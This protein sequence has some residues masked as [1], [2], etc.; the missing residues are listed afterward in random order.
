MRC[1][2]FPNRGNP[3][4]INFKNFSYY[5]TFLLKKSHLSRALLF[6]ILASDSNNFV[7]QF[8]KEENDIGKDLLSHLAKE[9]ESWVQTQASSLLVHPPQ[10]NKSFKSMVPNFVSYYHNIHTKILFP[11]VIFLTS[12]NES[13]RSKEGRNTQPHLPD[14]V[15]R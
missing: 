8:I 12:D 11:S 2:F 14:Q 9:K 4:K 1:F 13:P 5:S 3:N 6:K 7:R 15:G 10:V